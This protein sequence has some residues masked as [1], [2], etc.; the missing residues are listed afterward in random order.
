[1]LNWFDRVLAEHRLIAEPE[2]AR[3]GPPLA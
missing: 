1:V 3:R 2:A